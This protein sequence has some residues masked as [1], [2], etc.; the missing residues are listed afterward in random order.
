MSAATVR[1][2]EA[3]GGVMFLTVTLRHFIGDRLAT[4]LGA[5]Q[6]GFTALCA[7]GS[8]RRLLAPLGPIGKVR[9]V[10]I[11]F[12]WNGWH[13]HIHC[14]IFTQRPA[15]PGALVEIESAIYGA[16]A[17]YVERTLGR[18]LIAERA[19]DLR[20]V[21]LAN[22]TARAEYVAGMDA[23]LAGFEVVR[24]DTKDGRKNARTIREIAAGAVA[25]E[26]GDVALWHEYE[27]AT[28]GRQS[29][30]WSPGLKALL[31]VEDVTDEEAADPEEAG[32]EVVCELTMSDWLLVCG[33]VDGHSRVLD[34]A[35]DGG[36]PAVRAV[37]DD[38]RLRSYERH[39]H[40]SPPPTLVE[41]AA[42][43]LPF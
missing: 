12:G 29:L 17:S 34:A 1:H 35:E 13:P 31:G 21:V 2:L 19:V 36:A 3:G 7:A 4:T 20:P 40:R 10:E 11:T 26:M 27:M 16:L 23:M 24:G 8:V 38:L 28:K 39:R 42:V 9:A 25:G 43:E 22:A 14:L 18:S 30:V 33:A 41:A 32:D 15:S 5:I 6:G 37:I